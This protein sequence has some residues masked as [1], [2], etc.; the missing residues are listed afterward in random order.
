VDGG[1]WGVGRLG[2]EY[3][4]LVGGKKSKGVEKRK[5]QTC[6]SF[7][8]TKIV[9]PH[10]DDRP[11]KLPRAGT[12]RPPRPATQIPL[13]LFL[14]DPCASVQEQVYNNVCFMKYVL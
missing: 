5:K 13:T 8:S 4:V 3:V 7:L 14:P 6:F 11:V 1:V 9:P 2:I 12:G 10:N